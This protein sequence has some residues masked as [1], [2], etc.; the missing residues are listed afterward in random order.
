MDA[1]LRPYC[2]RFFCDRC[3]QGVEVCSWCDCGQRYCTRSC[4]E[5]ARL[6]SVR[7]AGAR[8]QRTSR[9]RRKHA[10]RQLAYRRRP[11]PRGEKVTHHGC[12]A[13]ERPATVA[14]C[15]MSPLI[16]SVDP[17]LV[18]FRCHARCLPFVRDDFLRVRRPRVASRWR[19][20]DHQGPRRLH[21]TPCLAWCAAGLGKECVRSQRRCPESPATARISR[22]GNRRDATSTG[23]IAMSKHL[24]L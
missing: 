1:G 22:A 17:F 5:V 10:A 11:R 18:C 4:R 12:R 20:R 16:R 24:E 9:G 6:R 3:R 21:E 23:T 15:S 13:G 7:E 14:G 19:K 2:R 8:Y